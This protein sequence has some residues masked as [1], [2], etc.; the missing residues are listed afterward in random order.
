M[1]YEKIL[2][3]PFKAEAS[4]HINKTLTAESSYEDVS[5]VEKNNNTN[6]RAQVICY[7]LM[8]S[9]YVCF[10]HPL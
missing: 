3:F 8:D 2:T 6:T 1:L 9:L 4:V 7:N 10:K 5:F